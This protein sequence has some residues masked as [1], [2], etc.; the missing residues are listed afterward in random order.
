MADAIVSIGTKLCKRCSQAKSAL[1]FYKS[2][3]CKDGLHGICKSCCSSKSKQYYIDNKTKLD[4]TNAQWRKANPERASEIKKQWSE[5]NIEKVKVS[6]Q[7][8]N[9]E[10]REYYKQYA[11]EHKERR[12]A[13]MV[14]YMDANRDRINKEARDKYNKETSWATLNPERNKANVAAYLAKNGHLRRVYEQNRRFRKNG[15]KLSPDIV[16][17]LFSLQKGKCPCCLK[18][19]GDDYHLDHKMPLALGG[20]NT[21]DNMQLLRGECNLQKNAKHPID[22]MQSKGF[23]L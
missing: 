8:W 9:A 10:N 20:S 17:R 16:Q 13:R 11:A 4:A 23:L 22:F 6:A 21:D 19:L 14:D 12:A 7:R 18:P 5:K 2:K 1:E 15:G 3:G